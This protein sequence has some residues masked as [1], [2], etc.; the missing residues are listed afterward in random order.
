[1]AASHVRVA[2][3]FRRRVAEVAPAVDHLF[4]RAAAD[5]Q[6]QSAAGD[7]IGCPGVFGH[8]VWI[9]VAHVDHG[10]ADL[11]GARACAN[12]GK[13]WERRTELAREV[14]NAK[15]CAIS[16]QVFRGNRELDRLKQG[17]GRRAYL[18]AGGLA[19]MPEREKADFF[20]QVAGPAPTITALQP[21]SL[22]RSVAPCVI[23]DRRG[24]SI[25]RRLCR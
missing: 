6:L 16:A 23:S 10:R 2:L 7:Q 11:D 3:A 24:S 17:V 22:P 1:M 12:G 5:A 13:Q 25:V 18:R 19:P 9:F 20:R 21:Y 15:V 8:V 14:V 4:R